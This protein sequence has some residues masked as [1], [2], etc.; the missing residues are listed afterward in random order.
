MRKNGQLTAV[1]L[2]AAFAVVG[3]SS[4]FEERQTKAQKPPVPTQAQPV[5]VPDT[6]DPEGGEGTGGTLPTTIAGPVSFADAEA[7]YQAKN[8]SEATSLFERYTERRPDNAW[9]HFMLGLS[10]SKAGDLAKAEG[11]FEEALKIDPDHLKSLINLSRVLI[12]QH[13]YDD[14]L[15]RLTH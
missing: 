14:A 5:A 13:R 12:D 6:V 8:Y 10:A 4:P 9:G 3:C 2:L 7:A 1:L 11:A 15:V